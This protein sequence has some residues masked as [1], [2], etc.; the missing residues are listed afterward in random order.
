MVTFEKVMSEVYGILLKH[1]VGTLPS[2]IHA[3]GPLHRRGQ[4]RP[5][6]VSVL[7]V[8]RANKG[9]HLVPDVIRGLLRS[10]PTVRFLVHNGAP[11]QMSEQQNA[12]RELAAQ[13]PRVIVDERVA[14]PV[15]WRQL[16]D[17]SD[18][19]L[20][21]YH[22]QT[23]YASPS[24]V[25]LEA[26]ANAI[27]FVGPAESTLGRLVGEYGCG[28]V[29]DKFEADSILEAVGK[30]LAGFDHF[31]KLAV[32]CAERFALTQGPE[33]T[34]DGILRYAQSG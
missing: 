32:E 27:P 28:S 24:A 18:L 4:M 26:I 22:P 14:G 17:D 8:Q 31:A 3:I 15:I 23:F 16:L 7:G 30:A 11:A 1:P 20:C 29:F 10:D 6:T 9:Y 5:L 13:E 33:Q 34:V 2:L 25:A 19:I 21:P 12:I